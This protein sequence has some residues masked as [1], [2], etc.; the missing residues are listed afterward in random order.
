MR[1]V[2]RPGGLIGLRAPDFDG[3]IAAPT[4]SAG[5]EAF[6]LAKQWYLAHGES[7]CV[8]RDL[9][10]LLHQAGCV[11]VIGSAAYECHGTPESIRDITGTLSTLVGRLLVRDGLIDAAQAAELVAGLQAWAEDPAAFL[12]RPWCEAVGWVE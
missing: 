11:R 5:A 6:R 8:G 10:G 1:R 4:G 9:R 2:L 12:A 3:H 7:P